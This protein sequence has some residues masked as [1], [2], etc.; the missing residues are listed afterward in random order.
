M[1]DPCYKVPRTLG[2]TK[3]RLS[4]TAHSSSSGKAKAVKAEPV[5]EKRKSVDAADAPEAKRQ[6]LDGEQLYPPSA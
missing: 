5:A 4:V 1:A 3:R 6:S 2:C